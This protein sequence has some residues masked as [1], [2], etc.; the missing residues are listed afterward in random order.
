[1][2][3]PRFELQRVFDDGRKDP[4][5]IVPVLRMPWDTQAERR[6]FLGA[7]LFAGAV[8]GLTGCRDLR[9]APSPADVSSA[10]PPSPESFCSSYGRA[11]GTSVAQ[12]AFSPDGKWVG[13]ASQDGT[14]KLWAVPSGKLVTTL[15]GQKNCLSLAFSPKGDR[16]VTAS[17]ETGIKLWAIP[18]GDIVASWEGLSL[19][20]A[21]SPDG[22]WLACTDRDKVVLREMPKGETA[23]SFSGHKGDVLSLA[24]NTDGT[25]LVSGS[26]DGTAVLWDVPSGEVVS[27]FEATEGPI[28]S[29]ALSADGAW[30]AAVAASDRLNGSKVKIWHLESGELAASLPGRSFSVGS[31][32]FSPDN[33]WLA[34]GDSEEY[35]QVQSRIVIKVWSFPSVGTEPAL[36]LRQDEGGIT[37]THFSPDSRWLVAGSYGGVVKLWTL[38]DGSEACHFSDPLADGSA[39]TG[40]ITWVNEYGQTMVS[41]LPCGSPIPSGAT[42]TCNCVPGTSRAPADMCTCNKVCTCVPVHRTW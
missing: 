40:Q 4:P 30:L 21:Y 15:W 23:A 28:T 16:L 38:P 36:I 20:L 26:R 2:K 25:R 14:A 34:F 12:V 7:G 3:V 5:E 10:A 17:L 33:R 37:G 29:V 27:R 32:S 8:I 6:G 35:E 13:S 42:C 41:V 11:H 1:M 22:R 24:F 18:T 19:E 9:R 39:A 31:V